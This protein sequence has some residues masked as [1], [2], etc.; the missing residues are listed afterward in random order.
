MSPSSK[1]SINLNE[2]FPPLKSAPSIEAIIHWQAHASKILEPTDL[3]NALTQRLP[4]Y[5]ICQ[6]QQRFEINASGSPDGTSEILHH[7]QWD[8]FRLQDSQNHHVVQFTPTGVT[9]SRLEP[10][11][12]WESF[13]TEA[14]RFWN[15]F[16]ELAEPSLI[17]RLDVR[18][19]N[20]I[21]LENGEQPSFYLT[22]KPSMLPS[23]ELF[24]ESFFY[25]DSY[26]IPGH[27]YGINWVRTIQPNGVDPAGGRA[28][29]VDIDVFTTEMLQLDQET[30]TQRLIEMR[31]LKNKVFFGCITEDAL[32]RFGV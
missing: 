23:L 19:I 28:V 27:P 25:Q 13:K 26:Q 3:R 6:P 20:R 8:G 11:E 9:F 14:L 18:Y 24:S 22:D 16:L 10:Y 30:L 2:E 31:W 21:P 17:Q 32:K 7:T 15:I 4:D 5:P 29:I 12:T 1:F